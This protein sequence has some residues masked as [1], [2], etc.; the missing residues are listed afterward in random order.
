MNIARFLGIAVQ[1][2]VLGALLFVAIVKLTALASH[3]HLF[4]YE[5]F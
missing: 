1:S 2:L 3:L 5:G 4:Q